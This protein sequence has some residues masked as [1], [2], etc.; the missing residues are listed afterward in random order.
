MCLWAPGSTRVGPLAGAGAVT[1]TAVAAGGT[2][3]AGA[4]D[5][6]F[7]GVWVKVGRRVLVGTGVPAGTRATRPIE[8]PARATAHTSSPIA[9]QIRK[10]MVTLSSLAFSGWD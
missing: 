7:A 4:A 5:A 1:T 8:Q 10:R 2:G 6:G 3:V 9:N